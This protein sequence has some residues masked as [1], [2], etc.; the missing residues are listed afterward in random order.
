MEELKPCPFCGST[1]I[2]IVCSITQYR[3]YYTIETDCECP[4]TFGGTEYDT[5][6]KLIEAWNRRS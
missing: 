5:E 6:Q 2:Y 4:F 3:D 1:D